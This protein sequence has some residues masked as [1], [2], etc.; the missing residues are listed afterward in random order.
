MFKKNKVRQQPAL[1][2][3]IRELPEKQRERIEQS[4]EGAFY[5][6]FF[7]RINEDISSVLYS[8]RPARPNAPVHGLVGWEAIK[9]G[10]SWSAEELYEAFLDNLQVCYALGDDCLGE[11]EIS[12]ENIEAYWFP[13]KTKTF[14]TAVRISF[15]QTQ[16]FFLE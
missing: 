5:R 4:W 7:C 8:E 6:E 1:I 14:G 11:T 13:E 15:S 2:S 12:D 10:L 3:A 9:A 16:V